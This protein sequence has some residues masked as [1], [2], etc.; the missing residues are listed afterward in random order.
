MEGNPAEAG[1]PVVVGIQAAGAVGSRRLAGAG[2]RQLAGAGSR[3]LAG[4]GSRRLA[5][6][7]RVADSRSWLSVSLCCRAMG[8]RVSRRATKL[9]PLC[10]WV[11][12][13]AKMC[14]LRMC[15]VHT[16]TPMTMR[17]RGNGERERLFRA[18]TTVRIEQ[19]CKAEVLAETALLYRK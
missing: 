9:L 14:L 1:T 11:Y 8:R 5:G 4:A 13:R 12:A 16:T 18:R 17:V 10:V 2:S 6:A 3:R 15:T 19:D 7:G